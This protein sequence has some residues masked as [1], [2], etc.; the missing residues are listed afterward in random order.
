MW[1]AINGFRS[2]GPDNCHPTHWINRKTLAR[3]W[4]SDRKAAPVATGLLDYFPDA[5]IAVAACSKAANEQHNPGSVMHWDRDKSGDEADALARHLLERG[6]RDS[7]NV[8]HSTKV[9]WRA[10]ANLQKEIEADGQGI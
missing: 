1:D 3:Y 5:C 10:L 8:R 7:D 6:T 2:F 4:P 9:A